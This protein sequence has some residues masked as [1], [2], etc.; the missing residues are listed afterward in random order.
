WHSGFSFL[1]RFNT[2]LISKNK[3]LNG[4]IVYSFMPFKYSMIRRNNLKKANLSEREGRK[5]MSLH[6]VLAVHGCQVARYT[7]CEPRLTEWRKLQYVKKSGDLSRGI[8][9]VNRFCSTRTCRGK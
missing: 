2:I 8:F 5:A 3:D 4:S 6:T 1:V 7:F 9:L